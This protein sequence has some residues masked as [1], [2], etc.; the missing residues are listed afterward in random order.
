LKERKYNYRRNLPHI[1]KAGRAHFIT[2][3]TFDS[4]AAAAR[5]S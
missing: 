4:M 5:G 1:E 2:F 3:D